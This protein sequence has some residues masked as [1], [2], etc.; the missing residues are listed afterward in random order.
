MPGSAR[1]REIAPAALVASLAGVCI[2]A[3]RPGLALAAVALT[4]LLILACARPGWIVYG[5]ILAAPLHV[6]RVPLAIGNL[7]AFR[8]LILLGGFGLCVRWATGRSKPAN[9]ESGSIPIAVWLCCA[10]AFLG[11]EGFI[12]LPRSGSDLGVTFFQIHAFFF[13]A[14]TLIAVSLATG[15]TRRR[16][17]I[18]MALISAIS[19]LLLIAEQALTANAGSVQ[20]LPFLTTSDISLDI[21]R[22]GV[23]FGDGFRPA[24]TFSDPNYF[25]IFAAITFILAD[26]MAPT[27]RA[28]WPRIALIV[29]RLALIASI[30]L[31]LSRSGAVI[32]G[33]YLLVSRS[34]RFS[35]PRMARSLGTIAACVL[36]LVVFLKP[37]LSF[38]TIEQR[39]NDP[40]SNAVHRET[41]R[42]ALEEG[43]AYPWT[44]IGLANLGAVLQQPPDRS[45][46]HAQPF[47]LFAE[48]GL[49]G[50]LLGGAALALPAI[51]LIR[52]RGWARAGIAVGLG[53]AV[54]TYD[55][56]YVLDVA[57]IWLAL[58]IA[59]EG[60]PPPSVADPPPRVTTTR[61]AER[62]SVPV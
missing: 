31:S 37:Y 55:F 9:R 3:L 34:A 57:A 23:S 22:T 19:P 16:T 11:Y 33:A 6:Y 25:A 10:V 41:R 18:I 32:V 51:A 38:S 13:L 2:G 60:D 30:A 5:A 49:I 35:I 28:R 50:L 15:A 56:L 27:V 36:V 54:W 1:I 53:V 47:T 43:S 58:M 42:V 26:E 45:S 12:E 14:V 17:L 24:G 52:R 39:V 46:A 29:L 8:G 7:S 4:G 48:E 61:F 44:G 21:N 62:S 59:P 20:Q 40:V